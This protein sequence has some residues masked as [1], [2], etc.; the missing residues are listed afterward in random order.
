MQGF[1]QCL[2]FVFQHAGHQP[3]A[4]FLVHLV[5]RK[6]RH[7][8]RHAVF[9][10]AGLVQ[11]SGR[12][13]HAA[14]TQCFGE[15]LGGDACCFVAH[16]FV[17]GQQ[18]QVWLF[19]DLVLVPALATGAAAYLGR[20]VL[21]VK[22]VNQLF[23]D[24]HV[25][26]PRLVLQVLHLLDQLLVAGEKRQFSVPV[27]SHQRFTNEDFTRSDRVYPAKVDPPAVVH[28]Q[29]VERGTLQRRDLRGLFLPMRV[30]QLLVQEMASHLLYPW[31]L[32]VGDATAK[33]AR[34]FD[35]LRRHNP[36]PRFFAELGARV[37]VELDAARAQVP[38]VLV[39]FAANVAQQAAQ[40]RQVQ[41]LVAGGSVIQMPALLAHHGVQL[42]MNVAPLAHAADVDKVVAQQA[43]VLA[44][45][46]FVL[47]AMAAAAVAQPLP[48]S[49]IAAEFALF[50]V[51]FGMRLVGL[52]LPVHRT[53]AHI[54]HAEC[55]GNH[56]HFIQRLPVLGL[57]NHA[58]YAR[59]QRQLGQRSAH[60]RQFVVVVDRA[61]LGQQ[62]VAIGNGAALRWFDESKVL[63]R[64]QMQRLHAKNHRSQRAAQDFG[65][66]K[67]GPAQKVLLVIQPYANA[68]GHP[69]AAASALVGRR[70]RHRLDHQLLNLVAKAVTLHARGTGINHIADAR[71][72]E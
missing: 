25:L 35:Q 43:F 34:G 22:G 55:A 60:R 17:T 53:V 67:A 58:A 23:I 40:H 68:V 27:A 16:Q 13:V 33:K 12:A 39:A 1:N 54:L 69:A 47:R 28:H 32:N 62:L 56:Q 59:V 26:P 18:Q 15:R 36:A 52:R 20:Q 31:R 30:K 57:Q 19:L 9:G 6:Q 4:A 72:R 63:D 24:Q 38:V 29:A 8:H 11:V 66:G 7:L 44:V 61:Q 51:E 49:Q 64:S 45:G 21:V 70:L 41:L 10:V 46:Q 14:K 5:Q 37:A 65:V 50:I 48:Q 71:H 3:L 42:R 2:G